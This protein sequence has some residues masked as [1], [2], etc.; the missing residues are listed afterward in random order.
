M[1]S[2]FSVRLKEEGETYLK[3]LEEDMKDK[4]AVLEKIDEIINY[5]TVLSS[6]YS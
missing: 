3:S 2:S 4:K 5:L 6:L 1:K